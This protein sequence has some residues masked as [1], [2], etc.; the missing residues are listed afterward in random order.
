[1]DVTNGR[2]Q[3]IAGVGT[4]RDSVRSIT[5]P[6]TSTGCPGV[7][8]RVPSL[9]VVVDH[10]A[11]P[12]IAKGV[13]TGWADYIE[14]LATAPQVYMKLSGLITEAE[15]NNWTADHLK[16]YLQYVWQLFGP[17][18]CMFGSDWPVCLLAGTWK[19]V[20]AGFTQALGPTP[21]LER[22]KVMGHTAAQFYGIVP[23]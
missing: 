3:G 15:W 7:V 10:I 2:Y 12:P 19:E 18:R 13:M 11:K 8:Q 1:M 22:N 14:E 23:A 6:A 4:K 5:A 20:L 9:K 21:Q 16:P 17:N